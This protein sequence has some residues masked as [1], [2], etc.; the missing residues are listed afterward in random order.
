MIGTSVGFHCPECA[1]SGRQKVLTARAL[2]RR[3]IVTQVLLAINVAVFVFELSAGANGAVS[4]DSTSV[5]R[6]LALRA[7]DVADGEWWRIVTAGFVHYGVFH[8]AMNMF[9]LWML[10]MQLEQALGKLRFALLY[11]VSLLAGSVGVLL[12]SPRGFTAGASGAIFGMLGAAVAAQRAQGVNLRDGGLLPVLGLNLA[13]TFLVPGISIG[14]HLG[15]LAGGFLVGVVFF[16]LGP[17][18]RTPAIAIAT[19]AALGAACVVGCLYLASNPV[20]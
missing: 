14:G 10:G 12:L 17:R 7:R 5:S 19:C 8:L 13:I 18:A 3:P 4:G 11:G 15:G 1:R 6:D 20:T 16:D 2:V 9:A